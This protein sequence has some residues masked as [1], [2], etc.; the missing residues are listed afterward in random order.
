MVTLTPSPVT[1]FPSTLFR[2]GEVVFPKAA[3]VVLGDD[4]ISKRNVEHASNEIWHRSR[5]TEVFV[6]THLTAS[7]QCI[8]TTDRENSI[9]RSME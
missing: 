8:E 4:G 6:Q 3:V 5:A 9:P 7:V 1:E 2:V